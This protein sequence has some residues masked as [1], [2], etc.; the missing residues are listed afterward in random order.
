[1]E[2]EEEA[3][4]GRKEMAVVQCHVCGGSRWSAI[5]RQAWAMMIPAF[6]RKDAAALCLAVCLLM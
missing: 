6:A 3:A 1:M 4:A 2:E 5:R